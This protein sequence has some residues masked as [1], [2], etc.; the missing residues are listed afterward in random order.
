M[1]NFVGTS[2]AS[3][4]HHWEPNQNDTI[5]SRHKNSEYR[6]ILL[7]PSTRT[8]WSLLKHLTRSCRPRNLHFP[9]CTCGASIWTPTKIVFHLS[10]S[11]FIDLLHS[12]VSTFQ[13]IIL[14]SLFPAISLELCTAPINTWKIGP[15]LFPTSSMRSIRCIL[16]TL[17]DKI[18]I[19]IEE[20]AF[21]KRLKHAQHY[22]TAG[23]TT[24]YKRSQ[25]FWDHAFRERLKE[26]TIGR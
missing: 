16:Q 11:K 18:H 5:K 21:W 3:F 12:A 22:L 10:Q 13:A 19:G 24:K 6:G 7:V 8:E 2:T 25:N 9:T 14:Y 20:A 26:K 15:Y 17:S 4:T 23:I 1:L